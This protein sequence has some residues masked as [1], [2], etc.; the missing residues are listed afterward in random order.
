MWMPAGDPSRLKCGE[1]YLRVLHCDGFLAGIPV[2]LGNGYKKLHFCGR[3][4]GGHG[5]QQKSITAKKRRPPCSSLWWASCWHPRSP[6]NVASLYVPRR[7]WWLGTYRRVW[8]LSA[9]LISPQQGRWG[10][11]SRMHLYVLCDGHVFLDAY[12]ALW[13]HGAPWNHNASSARYPINTH[14]RGGSQV[15]SSVS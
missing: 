12:D 6:Q 5:C 3:F 1:G 7:P 15:Q 9:C 13:F 2:R 4:W 11:L 14:C 8:F 10:L